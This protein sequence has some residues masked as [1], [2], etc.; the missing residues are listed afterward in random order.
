M[1]KKNNDSN[2]FSNKDMLVRIL[3]K[4]EKNDEKRVVENKRIY[5]KMDEGFRVLAEHDADQDKV[6][7]QHKSFFKVAGAIAL[8]VVTA[9][10]SLFIKK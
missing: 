6:I 2:G 5:D 3:D 4:I 10:I 8:A 1:A 7:E 9:V